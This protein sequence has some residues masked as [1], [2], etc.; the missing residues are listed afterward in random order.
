MEGSYA[1]T[2][3]FS[4][5]KSRWHRVRSFLPETT[6]HHR[7]YFMKMNSKWLFAF[8]GI[9]SFSLAAC[10][11]RQTQQDQQRMDEQGQTTQEQPGIGSP[12]SD[13]EQVISEETRTQESGQL[14]KETTEKDDADVSA[15][16]E[17]VTR[18]TE[19]MEEEIPTVTVG[20]QKADINRMDSEDFVALGLREDAAKKVT[21]YREQNGEFASVDDLSKVPGIDS[22]WLQQNKN[23]LSVGTQAAGER[24]SD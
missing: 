22:N 5:K 20:S 23:K 14:G 1:C 3:Y 6:I 8:A 21:D 11:D 2:A 18:E 19:K 10:T 15:V 12:E 4:G 24:A 13:D 17:T 7:E 9:L 16:R